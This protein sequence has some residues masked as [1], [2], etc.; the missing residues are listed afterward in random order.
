VETNLFAFLKRLK[1]EAKGSREI[2]GESLAA[3]DMLSLL[4][5]REQVNLK[6]IGLQPVMMVNLPLDLLQMQYRHELPM[7][8]YL[9]DGQGGIN[10]S[11]L[12]SSLYKVLK[13][14]QARGMRYLKKNFMQLDYY[15]M[16]KSYGEVG[17]RYDW[18][19]G[20]TRLQFHWND[21]RIWGK[22]KNF[23]SLYRSIKRVGYLG[24]MYIKYYITVLDVP[25]EVSRYGLDFF[26][27]KPYEIWGGH[28]R[29]AVLAALGYRSA[30]VVLLSDQRPSIDNYNQRAFSIK[31]YLEKTRLS[32]DDN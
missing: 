24:G 3:S 12:N 29:A 16:F 23:I 13:L 2:V 15:R 14:Y 27:W 31:K 18:Y 17:Y 21:E 6:R 32:A 4:P 19:R 1:K 11:I 26:E 28:H 9:N 8:D 30:D 7:D 10:R 25:F 5:E 20:K 22:L